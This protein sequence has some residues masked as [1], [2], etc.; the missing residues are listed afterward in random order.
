MATLTVYA[1]E[2]GGYIESYNDTY[3]TARAGS[4]LSAFSGIRV[5]QRFTATNICYEGFLQYDTSA[6]GEGVTVLSATEYINILLDATTTDFTDELRYYDW[7]DALTASDWVPGANLGSF[8]LLS[9]KVVASSAGYQEFPTSAA[10]IASINK[11]G[12]SRFV[13]SSNRLRIGTV[14]TNNEYVEYSGAS[15]GSKPY[16]V[17]NYVNIPILGS[18]ILSGAGNITAS[19]YLIKLG[20]ALLTGG[21]ALSA[22]GYTNSLVQF[23]SKPA[24]T[25]RAP[26]ATHVTVKSPTH[27]YTAVITPTP[28][29]ATKIERIVDIE[30]GDATVCQS[31]AEEL[32]GRWGRRQ[33]SVSGVI[34]LD[35]RLK[36]KEKIHIRIPNAGI[37]EPL[38]LQRKEHDVFGGSTSIVCGDII[39][40]DNELI[41]R[42]LQ[43]LINK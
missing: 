35:V 25:A 6:L 43:D 15:S 30:T 31:I 42:M 17:I 20:S 28:T 24:V 36:F 3:S 7:G 29:E 13:H 41:A 40:D 37:D 11:T 26:V 23:L 22:S 2:T 27:N 1:S 32:V 14:P 33:V 16:L 4:G 10:F 18:T 21:G 9:S 12:Y 34:P 38:V 19:A 5:G 39:L 8:P